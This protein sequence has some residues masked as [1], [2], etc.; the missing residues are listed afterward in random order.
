[1]RTLLHTTLAVHPLC[2]GGN[3]FGWTADKDQ[4]FE[5]LDRY[6]AAG[7]NF[8]DSADVYSVWADGNEGG[9]SESVIGAWMAQRGN[10]DD[11]VVATKVG[12]LPGSEGLSAATIHK[13]ADA[14]LQRLGT[15]HID[16]YYAHADDQ[17][18]PLEETLGAFDALA[19]A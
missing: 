6:A 2:L 3:V 19:S 14:S 1:M 16:L 7:G 15:D 11:M 13:A 17:D 9:E 5:V 4:S 12:K 8:V 18:T 10:R